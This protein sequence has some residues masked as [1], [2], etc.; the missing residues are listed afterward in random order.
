M[1][2]GIATAISAGAWLIVLPLSAGAAIVDIAPP[3][4]AAPAA[5]PSPAPQFQIGG[6]LMGWGG[7]GSALGGSDR[8]FLPIGTNMGELPAGGFLE[9]DSFG[10]PISAPTTP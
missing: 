5:A 10:V 7:G 6:D 4:E 9:L 1:R 8:L 3:A 2:K